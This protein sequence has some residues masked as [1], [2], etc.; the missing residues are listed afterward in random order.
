MKLRVTVTQE[1]IDKGCRW[2]GHGCAI[3]RAINRL[4]EKTFHTCQLGIFSNEDARISIDTM[5]LFTLPPEA[6]KWIYDFDF[7]RGVKPITFEIERT[8][9]DL[10]ITEAAEMAAKAPEMVCA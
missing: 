5:P 4:F 6:V 2:S 10:A 1:D 9:R 8:E 7:G 3:A